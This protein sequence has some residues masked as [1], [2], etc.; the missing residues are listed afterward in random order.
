MN[1]NEEENKRDEAVS[2]SEASVDE[3]LAGE[4]T[5]TTDDTE[6]TEGTADNP[7]AETE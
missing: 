4:A 1:K 5:K 2:A 6:G 3:E 7:L